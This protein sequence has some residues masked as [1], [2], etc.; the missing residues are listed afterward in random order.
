MVSVIQN[1]KD[2]IMFEIYKESIYSD[3]YRVVYFTELHE[4][5]K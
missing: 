4:H 1:T 5:N 3:K 2:K